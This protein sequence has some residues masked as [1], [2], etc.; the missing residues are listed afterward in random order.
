MA[1]PNPTPASAALVT[2][3]SSGIGADIARVLAKRGHGVVLVA[4]REDR[5]TALAEELANAHGVRAETIAVDL[6]TKA[7]RKRLLKR[8]DELG[9]A[10]TCWSTTPASAPPG[11]SSGSTASARS[12][13]CG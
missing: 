10:S 11:C 1:L 3:A 2:G 5:L 8:V 7:G 4:R 6:Q 12:D 9:L 13:W